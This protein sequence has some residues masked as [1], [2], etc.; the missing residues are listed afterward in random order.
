VTVC[1]VSHTRPGSA[2]FHADPGASVAG[3]WQSNHGRTMAEC[4]WQGK[5]EVCG[6]A[7]SDG[8]S[9]SSTRRMRCCGK[10]A[11]FANENGILKFK[12]CCRALLGKIKTYGWSII[13]FPNN[14]E[15]SGFENN[16]RSA[17]KLQRRSKSSRK[18]RQKPAQVSQMRQLQLPQQR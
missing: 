16:N 9:E 13:P 15:K 4:L 5:E 1:V 18:P 8:D 6:M 17:M 11:A 10:S 14:G 2:G 7:K 12:D 3:W